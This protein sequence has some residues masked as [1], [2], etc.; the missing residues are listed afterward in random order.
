MSVWL[1]N[2]GVQPVDDN[3]TVEVIFGSGVQRRGKARDFM[4]RLSADWIS[5]SAY[6]V[7]LWRRADA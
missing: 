7:I 1:E 6:D 3:V 4:W 2:H 5:N